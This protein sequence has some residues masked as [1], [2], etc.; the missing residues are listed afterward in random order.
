M[1][2]GTTPYISTNLTLAGRLLT[3]CSPSWYNCKVVVLKIYSEFVA[4]LS[5]L[6]FFSMDA[7]SEN[8]TE[9]HGLKRANDSIDKFVCPCGHKKGHIWP[10][11]AP[12]AIKAV[13]DH[14]TLKFPFVICF[15]SITGASRPGTDFA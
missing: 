13:S 5:L 6:A 1:E 7:Y 12:E 15:I 11:I 9:V 8:W 10:P 14:L 3:P 2:C 4:Y